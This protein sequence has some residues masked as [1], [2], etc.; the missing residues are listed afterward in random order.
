MKLR[1]FTSIILMMMI[2]SCKGNHS[3]EWL[4]KQVESV[5]SQRMSF[6]KIEEIYLE[7]TP[8]WDT[9]FLYDITLSDDHIFARAHNGLLHVWKRDGSYV[10]Q[11]GSWGKGPGEYRSA[12][13]LFFLS[14]SLIGCVDDVRRVINVYEINHDKVQFV[15]QYDISQLSK[16]GPKSIKAS[17]EHLFFNTCNGG[18][19]N[20]PRVI[21]VDKKV[22]TEGKP[23]ELGKTYF[24]F[25]P[26]KQAIKY[27]VL[28]NNFSVFG[29]SIFFRDV[30]VFDNS[31]RLSVF[32]SP[33][34]YVGN[35]KGD[36]PEKVDVGT[37]PAS[38]C[39]DNTKQVLLVQTLNKTGLIEI[40]YSLKSG[41][42]LYEMKNSLDNEFRDSILKRKMRD[43]PIIESFDGPGNSIYIAAEPVLNDK[44][45]CAILHICEVD[46]GLG[47]ENEE[48]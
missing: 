6:L 24:Y 20:D 1:I 10:D 38:F 8:K 40:A 2:T 12:Y 42:K 9:S 43:L 29:E 14:D 35:T 13:L 15:D 37:G 25:Y 7:K 33:Y 46:L 34:I 44:K 23:L 32:T 22:F 45:T 26:A 48:E 17:K 18:F 3:D 31:N 47:E 36:K 28:V 16:Y 41:E 21:K 30:A 39:V 5:L 19:D 27:T 11:V 4:K